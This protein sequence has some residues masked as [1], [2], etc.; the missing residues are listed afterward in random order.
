M[1]TAGLARA[2]KQGR[3]LGWPKM[4]VDRVQVQKLHK[5]GCSVRA[6]TAQLQLSKSTVPTIVT[7]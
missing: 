2:K 5:D 6:I 3:Q 1:G 7:A 4:I